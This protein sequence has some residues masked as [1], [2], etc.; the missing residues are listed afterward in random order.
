M[1]KNDEKPTVKELTKMAVNSAEWKDVLVHR[2]FVMD[3]DRIGDE[4][5]YD[6]KTWTMI[7]PEGSYLGTATDGSA[8]K[9]VLDAE[10]L[11]EL[12][13]NYVPDS[14]YI[15]CD[16]QSMRAPLERDTKAYGW[17][18][19]LRTMRGASPEYN[20]LY[21]LIKWTVDGQ[22]KIT[23]RAYRYMSPTM[24][25]D[26]NGRPTS[27]VNVAL[28]NRPNFDLPPILNS[29]D[30]SNDMTDKSVITE[31]FDMDYE[32][33]KTEIKTEILNELK[34]SAKA[35]DPTE[36]VDSTKTESTEVENAGKVCE[37]TGKTCENADDVSEK[38]EVKDSTKEE[39]S[40]KTDDDDSEKEVSE[41]TDKSE[42]SETTETIKKESL[43]TEVI[44]QN[45]EVLNTTA[46][47]NTKSS[48]NE[49]WRNLKGDDL[50]RWCRRHPEVC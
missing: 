50:I 21:A 26:E 28:T 24:T 5:P 6:F 40:D 13:K 34:D 35:D 38:T 32:K 8:I 11:D 23:D 16:H 43:N 37:N 36:T 1:K 7:A 33:M 45:V 9:E 39:V 12:A 19:E 14:A 22:R 46:V 42:K 4:D 2:G 29:E 3:A 27:L 18:Q 47:P 30:K 48:S 20:G 17:I 25:L 31:D 15:D 41:K 44:D 10:A 49:E